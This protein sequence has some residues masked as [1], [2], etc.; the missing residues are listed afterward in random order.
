M[1]RSRLV[2]NGKALFL[3]LAAPCVL[4]CLLVIIL[5]PEYISLVAAGSVILLLGLAY[6]GVRW[7]WLSLAIVPVLVGELSL[8][9]FGRAIWRGE[10]E[11]G[12]ALG[13][14]GMSI[15]TVGL[16]IALLLSRSLTAFFQQQ[17]S[18]RVSST[19]AK[20][21]RSAL[22]DSGHF[23]AVNDALEQ[24]SLVLR[25]EATVV[26]LLVPLLV[27]FGGRSL[28]INAEIGGWPVRILALACLS[29]EPI[30]TRFA[31]TLGQWMFSLRVRQHADPS[32]RISLPD[33]YAR[34]AVKLL[35]GVVSA[36][37]MLF[38][39]A[40]RTLHDVAVDSV[41]IRVTTGPMRS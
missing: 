24:L 25:A 2:I 38:N 41:V 37:A 13:G 31:A 32:R 23:V 12:V 39:E 10:L 28:L 1:Q 11:W 8:F 30:L 6:R 35:L 29:Y 20:I 18:H 15:A 22:S 16:G 9:H 33:A 14:V 4:V 34:S 40:R 7:A 36:V 27:F 21:G 3:A 26:D 19:E 5:M 17:H